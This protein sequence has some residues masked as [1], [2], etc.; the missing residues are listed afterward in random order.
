MVNARFKF[1]LEAPATVNKV[2]STEWTP[3]PKKG[4]N[5]RIERGNIAIPDLD[6]IAT[7]DT[8][9]F[10][11][12]TQ[13]YNELAAFPTISSEYEVYTWQKEHIFT[14]NDQGWGENPKIKMELDKDISGV[15][16]KSGKKY[17]LNHLITGQDG[18][19]GMELNL[20][21]QYVDKPDDDDIQNNMHNMEH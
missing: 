20:F 3:D 19:I 16:L 6:A 21:G 12:S 1:D 5:F 14:Q 11:I 15:L 9:G 4:E 13:S 18:A 7:G 17:F 2:K 10:S 8:I